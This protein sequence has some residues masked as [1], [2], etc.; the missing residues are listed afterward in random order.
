MGSFYKWS[1]W[2]YRVRGNAKAVLDE[3]YELVPHDLTIRIVCGEYEVGPNVSIG[4][5]VIAGSDAVKMVERNSGWVT[6]IECLI[7]ADFEPNR[8]NHKRFCFYSLN[9]HVKGVD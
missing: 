2:D 3:V 6:K 7:P 9:S 1:Y 4:D 8:H 5:C